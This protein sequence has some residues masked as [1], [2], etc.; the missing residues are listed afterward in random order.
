MQTK[1]IEEQQTEKLEALK[2]ALAK[3]QLANPDTLIG[4]LLESLAPPAESV[5]ARANDTENKGTLKASR[6]E[7]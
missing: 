3:T 1:N 6:D 4:K 2:V 5:K 7:T